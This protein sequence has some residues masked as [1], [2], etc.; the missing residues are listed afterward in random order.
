MFGLGENFKITVKKG[1]Q[2]ISD[3]CNYTKKAASKERIRLK[4]QGFRVKV[5]LERDLE[6]RGEEKNKEITKKLN[7]LSR[8]RYK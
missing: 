6:T 7:K 8:K 1:Q 4:K 2:W 5:Y 3:G